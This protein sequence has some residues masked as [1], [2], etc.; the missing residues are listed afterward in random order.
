MA[1]PTP[2]FATIRLV[3]RL[4][5]PGILDTILVGRLSRDFVDAL[6]VLAIVQANVSALARNPELQRAYG[7]YDEP[8]PDEL[9]R[10]VSINAIAHSLRLPYETVRRRI[11]RM[12]KV[13]NCEVSDRGVIVPAREVNSPQHFAAMVVVWERIRELYC[14]L[15]D[16]GLMDEV[17]RK[18]SAATEIPMRAVARISSDYMLRTVE[19]IT[20]VFDGLVPGV[21]WFAVLRANTEDLPDTDRG[22][23]GASEAE[24]IEDGRRR[25]VR[26]AEIAR[27]LD[28]PAETIR[29]YAAELVEAGRLRRTPKGLIAP[30]AVLARPAA[31]KIMKDSYADL[32]R[33]YAGLGQLGVLAE[34]DRLSPPLRGAA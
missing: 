33:M 29:R 23:A 5:V 24:F 19:N 18:P 15:R 1:D 6:I 20:T 3:N 9:R 2:T 14:R 12:E 28:A 4:A 21:V 34:W 17:P 7:A 8:P 25:P 27:R 10:P 30:A 16:L 13:G 11:A 32:M 22:G 31:L 26:P